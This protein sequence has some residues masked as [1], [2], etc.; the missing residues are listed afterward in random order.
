MSILPASFTL[1]RAD[2]AAVRAVLFDLDGTLWDPEPHVFSAY[3][4]VFRE[5]GQELTRRRW[6]DVIG[7]VGFDLWSDLEERVGEPLDRTE[8]ESRVAAYKEEM[9][10]QMRARPGVRNLLEQVDSA[11]LLRSIVSNSPSWW[12]TRYVRQC[13]IGDGWHSVHSP[14]RVATLPK[15]APDLYHE[16]L[17]RLG[18]SPEE[19]IA[20]EDSPTGIRAARA[21]G[22]RC[23]TVPNDMTAELDLTHADLRV[24]S[25]R[26]VDLAE[27]IV[28]L[29]RLEERQ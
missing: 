10:S 1:L 22:V 4:E 25:F 29:L 15:P 27:I 3:A 18:L 17:R 2:K 19:A 16:A 21:A 14:D 24:E 12:I 9:L 23:V 5:H 20:F 7:T 8:L 13:G 11:G 6:G 28:S 26:H